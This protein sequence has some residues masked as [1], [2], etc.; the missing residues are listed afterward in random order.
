M[1]RTSVERGPL[2]TRTWSAVACT[3]LVAA[4]FAVYGVTARHD[5][6]SI[7]VSEY[8]LENTHLQR[9]FTWE[10]VQWAWSAKYASNWHPLT[11]MSHMLD[12]ELFGFAPA[13][14]NLVNAGWH[15]LNSVLAFFLFARLF[16]HP[17]RALFVAA[18][19]A[20]H[21]QHVESVAWIAER[22]DVLSTAFGL[23]SLLAWERWARSGSRAGYALAL[24][25]LALGLCTK[26]MLVTW[27]FVLLLLD[28]WPFR[29]TDRGWALLVVEKLPFFAL[30]AASA[31][32]T[33][34]AQSS[35]GAVQSLE[36][37]PLEWRLANV[38]LSYGRYLLH[39]VW[40]VDLIVH[41]PH[42]GPTIAM[43][44]V[45]LSAVVLVGAL[46]GGFATRAKA[47]WLW[48]GAC[49]FVGTLVPVIGLVQVGGQAMADRYSYVPLFGVFLAVT[50]SVAE[51]AARNPSARKLVAL[52]AVL[53]VAAQFVL[54]RAQVGT[55]KNSFTLGAEVVR[56]A[57]YSSWGWNLVAQHQMVNGNFV[58]A[59]AN[60]EKSV[61]AQ[62][63][64]PHAWHM[65]GKALYVLNEHGAA[66]DAFRRAL[67]LQPANPAFL[68]HLAEVLLTTNRPAEAAPLVQRALELDERYSGA[69]LNQ[70]RLLLLSSD[71]DGAERE[72]R[73]AVELLPSFTPARNQLA[74]LLMRRGEHAGAL[75]E[76]EA[77]L[78]YVPGDM[79]ARRGRAR[80]LD[81]LGRD[82]EARDE[83]EALVA[84]FPT[85][86]PA[87]GDLA[88]LLASSAD[89]ALRDVSRAVI[90]AEKAVAAAQGNRPP[91]LLDA[92]ALAYAQSGRFSEA[93]AAAET[94]A[95]RATELGDAEQAKRIAARLAAYREKRVD[96]DVPR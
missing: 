42:P 82:R 78:G 5:F 30:A 43:R 39:T 21:P 76:I 36:L 15:A 29:R 54:A 26:P 53:A 50:W 94:A 85:F 88:W 83:L 12:V 46:V 87:Q 27:P 86:L 16:G 25:L 81:A 56:V 10:G 70:G 6:V 40:P 22:K 11:W 31:V 3:V 2:P 14:H 96:L 75:K 19:F 9:G 13:G 23:V 55:W 95:A 4:V 20:L 68:N 61:A 60:L 80:C 38:V 72:F 28:A 73:R 74:R 79:E 47:P 44:D 65:Y 91:G 63:G 69:H 48:L 32:L 17:W 7:D 1:D 64:D 52:V 67:A 66:E 24:V 62:P 84:Q 35:S 92:L 37:I 33:W 18:C 93:A 49:F 90:V 45:T 34:W 41:Y 77:V 71:F 8:L 57:P 59:A 89:P 51:W 58:D